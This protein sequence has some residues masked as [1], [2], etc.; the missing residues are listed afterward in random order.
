MGLLF[1]LGILGEVYVVYGSEADGFLPGRAWV[2]WIS[3]W[4]NNAFAPTLIILSFLL[5][6]TGRLPSVRWRPVVLLAVGVAAVHAATAALAPGPLQDN[7][8]ENPA[9]IES[10]PALRV[11]AEVSVLILVLPLMLLSVVS[12]FA[13]LRRSSGIERQQLKWFAYAA[14]LL[15]TDLLASNTLAVLLGGTGNRIADFVPFLTFVITLSGIPVAMGVA[16]L[17]HRLYDI[18]VIINRTLVYGV[19]TL[20]L[21]MVYVGCIV[22]LQYVLRAMTG[23]N[24]QLVIVASTLAIAALFNPLRGRIQSFI[25]RRFYRKKYDAAK[26]LEAFSARLRAETDLDDLGDG[27]VEVVRE[28]VQ[29]AHASLW[30]RETASNEKLKADG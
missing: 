10:A 26:T 12:L 21:V 2:G 7:G 9:G 17:R 24:S 29:P 14:A 6:P 30:L 18:D 28:T 19:L 22:S 8:I 25:D 11:I 16:I 27:L 15:A 13:R 5:F 20:S 23:G 1:E 3:Q 4:S